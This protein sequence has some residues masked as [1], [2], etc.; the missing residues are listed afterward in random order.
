[1][2]TREKNTKRAE[3]GKTE[4]F[5]VEE[6]FLTAIWSHLMTRDLGVDAP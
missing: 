5:R 4:L 3:A 2:D 6:L 1:M